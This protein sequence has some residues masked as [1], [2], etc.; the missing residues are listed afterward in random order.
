MDP[1]EGG[2]SIHLTPITEAAAYMDVIR[3]PKPN[4][5]IWIPL[6]N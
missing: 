4:Q 2:N 3:D 5:M 1:S 6:Q